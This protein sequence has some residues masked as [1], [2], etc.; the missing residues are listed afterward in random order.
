MALDSRPSEAQYTADF[1]TNIISGVTSNWSGSYWIGDDTFSMNVLVIQSNG[2]LTNF[3]GLVGHSS[4]SNDSAV[5]SDSGSVWI[6]HGEVLI[7]N[8]GG[9]NSLTVSNGGKVVSGSGE[10]GIAS[11]NNSVLVS[12]VGS[13]WTNGGTLSVSA[14]GY[15]NSLVISNGGKVITKD[16]IVSALSSSQNNRLLVQ[17]GGQDFR[18]IFPETETNFFMKELNIQFTFQRN[19][20][21]QV[22]GLVLRQNGVDL[23]AKRTE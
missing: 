18:E 5:V 8:K 22:T 23:P 4:S 10:L 15:G 12:D 2:V 21:G 19:D 11:S 13:V 6:N 7:G 9:G 16:A 1:Q 14:G 3:D 17:I 20:R